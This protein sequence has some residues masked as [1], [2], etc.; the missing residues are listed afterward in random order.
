MKFTLFRS[1]TMN[2]FFYK[3]L[4]ATCAVSAL[5]A[6]NSVNKPENTLRIATWN[7]EHLAEQNNQGCKARTEVDYEKLQAY[8]SNLNA[9]IV[10]LQEVESAK[11]VARVFTE[12]EWQIIMSDR[13]DS[14]TYTC[15]KSGRSS[16]QQKVAF[17]VKRSLQVDSTEQIAQL[18]APRPGLRQG[19]QITIKHAGKTL[20][21]VNVHLKSGCFVD[22][23]QN[24]DREACTVLAKQVKVLDSLLESKSLEEEHWLVLGDFNHRLANTTNRFRKDLLFAPGLMTEN[25]QS[26]KLLNNLTDGHNGCHPKY[27]APIDHIFVSSPFNDKYQNPS[28][29]FHYF[30]NMDIEYMLSDHCALSANFAF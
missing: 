1:T 22:D 6:C 21:L 28:L 29:Q 7:V 12:K 5:S 4:F 2:K 25:S 18:S 27:P 24:S 17:A 20:N 13:A 3:A 19:L 26:V 16:T 9:D 30:D 10:A 14:E 8:A 15:R 23:Y 11:A